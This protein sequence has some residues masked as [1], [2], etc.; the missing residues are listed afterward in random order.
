M[1]RHQGMNKLFHASKNIDARNNWFMALSAD[2]FVTSAVFFCFLLL[3]GISHWMDAIRLF[4]T[5][6]WMV[7][8][9]DCFQ[10]SLHFA[11]RECGGTHSDWQLPKLLLFFFIIAHKTDALWAPTHF[12]C[13]DD[14]CD[15]SNAQ[16]F[17]WNERNQYGTTCLHLFW[18]SLV[19][20]F[21]LRDMFGNFRF[22]SGRAR[23][24]TNLFN[25]II[26]AVHGLPLSVVRVVEM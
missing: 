15:G 1:A 18:Y 21:L 20:F 19:F 5:C 10:C 8:S 25:V 11:H 2:L 9:Q 23:F 22:G 12:K 7:F 13:V 6:I 26:G 3:L 14:G 24:R 4:N 17:A 16:A